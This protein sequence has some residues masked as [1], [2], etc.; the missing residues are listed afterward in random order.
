MQIFLFVILW[1]AAINLVAQ[2]PSQYY[3]LVGTY[4]NGNSEGIYV[5]N[6]DTEKGT[7]G[8]AGMAKGVPN[9]SFLAVSPDKYYVYAV[10]ERSPGFVCS[11]SFKNGSLNPINRQPSAGD[12][13]CY[14]TV[15]ATGKWVVV[16][17]YGSGTL[18]IMRANPDGSLEPFHQQIVHEGKSINT[19]RQEKPHI[20]AAVFNMANDQLLVPDLGTD[21]VYLYD[22]DAQTGSLKPSEMPFVSAAPGSGPRHIDW[23]PDGNYVYLMEEL[24]GSVT[25]FQYK[26]RGLIP[27]Q[28]IAALGKV[29]VDSEK[30][31]A[32]IHVSPDGKH[33]YCSLRG[34][35]NQLVHFAINSKDGKLKS[36]G[37]YSTI[38]KTPRN[39]TIDPTGN[40]LLVANQNTDDIF[41]FKRNAKSG[42]LQFTGTRIPSPTPVCM[43][44]IPKG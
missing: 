41:V 37:L 28:S 36:K 17:N 24:S 40:F 16:A 44:W 23:H 35:H 13:P 18:G 6:F 11:F 25:V 2:S 29:P 10:C 3:L 26:N 7:A 31:G 27:I 38:G 42:K 14:V 15:D 9:P 5:Y 22:F 34:N 20:H 21:K 8:N 1:V 19:T 33:L 32:D 39:F 30:S 4:T 43:K 12:G